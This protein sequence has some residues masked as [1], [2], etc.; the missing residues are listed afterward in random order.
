[1][2]LWDLKEETNF[3][4]LPVNWNYLCHLTVEVEDNRYTNERINTN[5]E[6]GT[7]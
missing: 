2:L 7:E 3:K 1:M 4:F 6:T 5:T